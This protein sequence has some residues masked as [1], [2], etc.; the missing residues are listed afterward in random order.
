[1]NF[2]GSKLPKFSAVVNYNRLTAEGVIRCFTGMVQPNRMSEQ[3]FSKD[4]LWLFC[5]E[6]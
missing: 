6:N 3:Q 1:L 2:R 4:K 5:L